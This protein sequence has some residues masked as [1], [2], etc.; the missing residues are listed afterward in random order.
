[1]NRRSF[2]SFLGIAPIA[3]P[4]AAV[5]ASAPALSPIDYS[6]LVSDVRG[7]IG[8]AGFRFDSSTGTMTI[9]AESFYLSHPNL[10]DGTAR[11]T[12]ETEARATADSETAS[13]I[14]DVRAGRLD[15][16]MRKRYGLKA[17]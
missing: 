7:R 1:M 5:A 15:A 9:D 14:G 4:A 12:S 3:A 13:F 2:L 17:V 10:P 11:I 8:S 16:V 6:G